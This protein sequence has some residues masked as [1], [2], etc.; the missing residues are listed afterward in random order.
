MLLA[1]CILFAC[2][3][4]PVVEKPNVVSFPVV[5]ITETSAKTGGNVISD[6]GAE[7]TSRGMCWSINQNPTIEEDNKTV[8]GAGTGEFI[9]N[10]N[11][12]TDST[13]YYIRAYAVN[14]VGVS[15]GEEYRFVTLK[16]EDEGNDD[17]EGDDDNNGDDDENE[18]DDDNNGDDDEV[19]IELPELVTLS[20]TQITE[21]TAMSGGNITS[22]GGA[23]VTTK[24]VCW[25]TNQNPTI[26]DSYVINGNGVGEYVS[27]ITGLT[28]NTTY[29]VRAYATNSKGTA[30]GE[31]ISFKTMEEIIIVEPTIA[32]LE[33]TEVTQTAAVCGG[34]VSSDGGSEVYSRGVCWSVNPNPTLNDDFTTQGAGLG[35]FTCNINE[36][37]PN[38]IYYVR[39]FA[40][41]DIGTSYGEA[42]SFITLEEEEEGTINGYEYVDLGLP[43]GLKWA[44]CNIG[45][46]APYESGDYFAWGEINP[47][48]E[49]TE[50]N[51]TSYGLNMEDIAGDPQ[52]DAARANWGATWKVPSKKDFEELMNECTWEWMVI[53]GKGC[54]KVT[55]SN[56]NYIILPITGYKYGT[57]SYMDDF[58]YYW[59]STPISTYEQFSYDFFFDQEY[60]LSMG[61]DE[62]C[63]GQAIRPV[64]E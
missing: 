42:V 3:P 9:S 18:E 44:T 37:T 58:G 5:E 31:E 26:E 16:L 24:G 14:S 56:G 62:R 11:E 61:F 25:S 34:I 20:V 7:V 15:Y 30:Y 64:S 32:T 4:N 35:E 28:M 46:S 40:T 21:T 49:F 48:A 33:V 63:Y 39:A 1:A 36:L 41:N 2:E 43:S 50:A 6:G 10:I 52:Y 23:E 47:K 13:T 60:N 29:Y 45:A 54:K 27:Y 53:N 22:D 38:T 51:C 55:G 17:D 19:V 59:T 12:L 8:D 57:S